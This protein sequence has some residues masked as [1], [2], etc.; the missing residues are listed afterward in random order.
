MALPVTTARWGS[1]LQ[2]GYQNL[3]FYPAVPLPQLKPHQVLIKIKCV[4]LNYRD[5]DAM[6]GYYNSFRKHGKTPL[7]LVPCSDGAGII[8]GIGSEVEEEN[9]KVDDE[10]LC[11][12]N[13]EHMSGPVTLQHMTTGSGMPLEGMLTEYK[14][15][16]WY[17]TVKKPSYLTW[18]QSVVLVGGG[19][20]V[21]T[22]FFAQNQQSLR[23][24]GTILI[25]G[26]GGGILLTSSFLAY[27][28]AFTN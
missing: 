11:L 25:L 6:R 10:V 12:Y 16:P 3:Q 28:K 8:V 26:T 23:P 17:S 4:S 9:V 5:L 1:D 24:G 20:T 18:E 22:S 7:P 19:S 2:S 14:I 27:L 15:L 13:T 21:W